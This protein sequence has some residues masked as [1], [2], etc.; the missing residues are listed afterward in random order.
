[1]QN[2]HQATLIRS[3][4]NL[5]GGVPQFRIGVHNQRGETIGFLEPVTRDLALDDRVA[6]LLCRWRERHKQSFLSQSRN[7][8]ERTRQ[9]LKD[10]LMPDDGR[11]LFLIGTELGVP[12]GTSGVEKITDVDGELGNVL[13][14]EP[15]GH[16]Q[17]FFFA[18]VALLN[19]CFTM[20]AVN[21]VYLN[22]FSHNT[23]A[24]R[25][26]GSVGFSRAFVQA[27]AKHKDERG[28]LYEV[29]LSRHPAPGELS[30]LTMDMTRDYF[31]SRYPWV[32]SRAQQA[33]ID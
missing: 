32:A 16:A 33:S 22:V 26:Y 8:P 24:V 27:L 5:G 14:G 21:R 28:A 31:L 2:E 4:K 20:L 29:D 25:F 17:L 15:G 11:I 10:V 1:M 19:W 18:E 9:W 30:L 12:L 23:R 13:R 6:G 3:W 7:S